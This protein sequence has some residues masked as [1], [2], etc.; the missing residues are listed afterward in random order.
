MKSDTF[1]RYRVRQEKV[2]TRIVSIVYNC[3]KASESYN[4]TMERQFCELSEYV[5]TNVRF[6]KLGQL[7]K[8]AD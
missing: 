6:L 4:M 7:I 5:N 8:C 2:Y 3:M 1:S